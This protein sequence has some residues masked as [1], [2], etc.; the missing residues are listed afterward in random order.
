M[1]Y[2]TVLRIKDLRPYYEYYEYDSCS[3]CTYSNGQWTYTATAPNSMV[4]KMRY[5]TYTIGYNLNGGTASGNPTSYKYNSATITLNNPTRAGYTFIGWTGS[6]DVSGG[7]GSYTSS[8]PYVVSGRDHILGNEFNVAEGEK[9]RVFVKGNRT[10]GSLNLQGGIWYTAQTS[11]AP[12]DGYGGEFTEISAGTFYK[13]IT[14]PAGKTKGKF[15]IQLEQTSGNFTTSWNLYDMHVIKVGNNTTIPAGSYGN[16]SYTANW[17]ANTYTLTYNGNGGTASKTSQTTKYDTAWGA[18]ATATRTGYSFDGWYTAASGGTQVTDTTV[19]KGNTT[20]YAKWKLITLRSCSG[21]WDS[22][23]PFLGNSTIKR[24]KVERVN[25]VTSISGHSTNDANCW[26]VSAGQNGK[27]LAWYEDKDSDGYYEVTIGQDGGINANPYSSYLFS[28]IGYNGDDTTVINGIENLNTKFAT[29]MSYM[30]YECNKLTS[31]DVSRFDTSKVTNMSYMFAGN[32]FTSDMNLTTLDVSRFDTSNVTNMSDMFSGCSNLTSLDVS[33]FDTSNVTNMSDMFRGC[34][35]LTSLNVSNFSTS[36]VTNMWGM[37]AS[38][39]LFMGDMKLTSLDV[40]RF[41]TS[42]VTNMRAMFSGCYKLTSLNVSNFD[43][44]NVTDMASM[45]YNCCKLT[46]L[47]V[48]RFDTSK[49]TNMSNMFAENS[50]SGNMNLT[51]LDVSRFDT[52]NVTNMSDMF[53]G[54]SNL[55]SLNVSKFDTSNVTDM[56]SMFYN[57]YGVTSLDVSRFDTSNVTNMSDMFNGCCNLTS[58]DVSKFDT[59]KVTD[60]SQMFYGCSNLTSLDVSKFDTSKV[61]DMGLMFLSCAK[62]K[63]IY[64]GN[65]WNT[66]NV[67]NSDLM[68]SEATSLVGGAGT[69]YNSSHID[70]AYAHIDGGT[71]NPGY[72]T[73]K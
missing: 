59:S 24:N 50:F 42:N 66:D 57:C 18:L 29:N 16:K 5:K 23:S 61:T 13:E 69:T 47:D 20:V 65:K 14:I 36:K 51:S 52:S 45:F 54:C 6:N 58:L 30:F 28:Y 9:Y 46:S 39:D 19:C 62:L 44:S 31:L 67:T 43:T 64:A 7:L 26:D 21:E 68:F 4:I 48:S 63:T 49:V 11:G 35:N 34:S 27:I 17:S 71:S 73:S 32:F 38:N 37:F 60:M 12:Y 25:L 15:Y 1:P 33:K 55:T 2:G 10:K 53:S 8:S 3:G 70:K 22:T 40:S 56:S 41:D 72:F